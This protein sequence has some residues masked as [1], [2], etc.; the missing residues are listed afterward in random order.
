M[1][2]A[3]KAV[4]A[5]CAWSGSCAP[6][7]QYSWQKP[8]CNSQ[9]VKTITRP[10]SLHREETR[11]YTKFISIFKRFKRLTGTGGC[12]MQWLMIRDQFDLHNISQFRVITHRLAVMRKGAEP[13]WK[14][15][16]TS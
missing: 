8:C 10:K 15:M 9:S 6:P 5:R 4:P 16:F 7:H 11:G 12:A 13:T 2:D 1:L 3:K 14:C